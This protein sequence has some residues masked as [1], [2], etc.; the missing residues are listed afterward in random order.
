MEK[1]HVEALETKHAAVQ[2]Q[3]DAEERRPNPDD[4]LLHKLKKEK[5]RLKDEM[6]GLTVH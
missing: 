5:L 2:L 3:I 1:A 6:L 4:I